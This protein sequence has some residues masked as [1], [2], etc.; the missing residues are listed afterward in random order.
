MPDNVYLIY[1]KDSFKDSY[2]LAVLSVARVYKEDIIV[3]YNNYILLG[4][5]QR[6]S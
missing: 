3:F 1:N 4:L 5:F 2:F 6:E